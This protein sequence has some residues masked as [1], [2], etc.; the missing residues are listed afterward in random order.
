MPT[1][2]V[3]R[4]D[5]K[6]GLGAIGPDNDGSDVAASASKVVGPGELVERAQVECDIEAGGRGGRVVNIRV[7]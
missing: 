4:Y 3:K 2:M 1:G 7:L 5:E 6:Q